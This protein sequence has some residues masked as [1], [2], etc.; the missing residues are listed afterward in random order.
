MRR[1]EAG[2][3]FGGRIQRNAVQ[4]QPREPPRLRARDLDADGRAGVMADEND[5]FEFQVIDGRLDR[6]R[7]RGDVRR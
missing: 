3:R 5:A 2:R 7:I 6:P 4:H 1:S